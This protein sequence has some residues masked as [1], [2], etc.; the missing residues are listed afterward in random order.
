M[1]LGCR[2]GR[3]GA[4]S[5]A[6]RRRCER[7][8]WA[9]REGLSERV[10]AC[11]GKVWHG[12]READVMARLL[13]DLGVPEANIARERESRTTW[14]NARHGAKVL[15]ELEVRKIVLVTC[16][17]HQARALWAFERL[18]F[19]VVGLP[20]STPPG[21]LGWLRRL[22]ESFFSLVRLGAAWRL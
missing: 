1:V 10:V 19:E 22:R 3:D 17:F 9:F 11:G 12:H 21:G 6:L 16:D 13:Q 7:A 5:G 20:C 18:G 4:P 2:V 14:G 15:R 8:A